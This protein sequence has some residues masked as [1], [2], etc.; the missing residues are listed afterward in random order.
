MKKALVLLSVLVLALS[1]FALAGCGGDDNGAELSG[2]Y[3]L[4]SL[5]I[6]GQDQVPMLEAGGM[7]FENVYIEF[8]PDGNFTMVLDAMGM[9][10]STTGSYTVEG[11]TINMSAGGTS[12][13]G[14]KDGDTITLDDGMGIMT[15][16]KQ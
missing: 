7:S 4:S 2:R 10:E 11:S 12:L 3:T 9:S 5:V 1:V 15:F 13:E 8:T 14:I 16:E 6:D